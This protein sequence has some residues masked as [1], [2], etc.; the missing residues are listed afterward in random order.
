MTSAGFRVIEQPF[1]PQPVL[2]SG[3]G[4]LVIRAVSRLVKLER[5]AATIDLAAIK[6]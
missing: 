4:W 3:V 2:G 5:L 6:I 1:F